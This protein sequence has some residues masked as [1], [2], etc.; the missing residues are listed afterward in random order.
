VVHP[1]NHKL[2]LVEYVVYV[3]NIISE[4]LHYSKSVGEI[5]IGLVLWILTFFLSEFLWSGLQS[6]MF[7]ACL[8]FHHSLRNRERR[9]A[10]PPIAA[11]FGWQ[12]HCTSLLQDVCR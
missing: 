1:V 6:L 2:F 5:Y 10:R 4:Y 7:F 9:M 3:Q 11:I 12:L 8:N